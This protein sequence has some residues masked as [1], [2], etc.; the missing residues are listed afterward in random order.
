MYTPSFFA[1]FPVVAFGLWLAIVVY[2]I[3]MVTRLVKGVERIAAS[4]ERR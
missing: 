2:L 3:V 1:I 4:L